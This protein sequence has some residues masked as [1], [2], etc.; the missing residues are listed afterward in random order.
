MN[1]R[2]QPNDAN[3]K[4]SNIADNPTTCEGGHKAKRRKEK[5]QK[6]AR[7]EYTPP[8]EPIPLPTF[9]IPMPKGAPKPRVPMVSQGDDASTG[10][11]D[12]EP[13]SEDDDNDEP[14]APPQYGNHLDSIEKA[15]TLN[16]PPHQ[17]SPRQH[18]ATSSEML[19]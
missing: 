18:S 6:I 12:T 19:S 2:Q 15:S 9:S 16:K 10:T 3:D 17:E 5:Q 11:E 4:E 1:E 8:G 14:H 13:L 7:E